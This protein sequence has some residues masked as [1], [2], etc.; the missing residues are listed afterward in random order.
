MALE[1]LPY[2]ILIDMSRQH[3]AVT[4]ES[5]TSPERGSHTAQDWIIQMTIN[6]FMRW[7][8]YELQQPMNL[9]DLESATLQREQSAVYLVYIA[10]VTL[11][12]AFTDS[13]HRS[14]RRLGDGK[15][16]RV[17]VGTTARATISSPT[18]TR[19]YFMILR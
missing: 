9:G 2:D 17:K 3:S 6:R 11:V 18:P 16:H 14:S 15:C 4:V 5:Q 13:E 7:F 12:R 8:W 19:H 1:N 10:A